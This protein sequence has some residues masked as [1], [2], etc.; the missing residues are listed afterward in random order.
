MQRTFYLKNKEEYDI[1][2]NGAKSENKSISA[3]INSCII[4][5]LEGKKKKR[6]LNFSD[7]LGK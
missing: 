4:E 5:H 2:V 6:G 1:W 3:F 7:L